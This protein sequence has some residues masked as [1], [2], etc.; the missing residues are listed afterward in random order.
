VYWQ[1]R[2]QQIKKEKEERYETICE[3]VV[4]RCFALGFVAQVAW[5]PIRN[6]ALAGGAV[7]RGHKPTLEAIKLSRRL[8]LV[9]RSS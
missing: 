3:E 6:F 7:M 1:H 9:L 2:V 8:T 5:A 4:S